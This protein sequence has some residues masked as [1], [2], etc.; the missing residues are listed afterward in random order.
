MKYKLVL[1]SLTIFLTSCGKKT[2]DIEKTEKSFA[3]R[4]TSN[5]LFVRV[6]STESGINFS[7]QVEDG[8]KFNVLTYRNFYNGAGV[9]IGDIN[10]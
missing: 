9:S 4:S 10:K 1:F 2:N 8:E 3:N 5:T 6:S 7:N